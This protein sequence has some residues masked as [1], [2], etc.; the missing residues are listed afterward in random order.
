MCRV[1]ALLVAAPKCF[2]AEAG[3]LGA[4]YAAPEG[5]LKLA[6]LDH[7]FAPILRRHSFG[8]PQQIAVAD[9]E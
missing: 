8:T 5:R 3:V 9:T 2:T 1:V 6:A 4:A 7:C